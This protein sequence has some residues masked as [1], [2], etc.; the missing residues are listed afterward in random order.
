MLRIKDLKSHRISKGKYRVVATLQNT[1]YL[2]TYV[3]KNA[4]KVRRDN[5]ISAK[6][7]VT[8]GKVVDGDLIKNAG[9]I[10]GK[11]SYIW[12]WSQGADYSTKTVEWTIK[13]T[14]SRPLKVSVEAWAPK[15]GRDQKM[16]TI[17]K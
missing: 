11:L 2:A 12:Q 14:G 1:G 10:L 5:P 8:G 4:L 6:I 3:T 7:Q 15:V 9:H 17:N 16:I 13:A